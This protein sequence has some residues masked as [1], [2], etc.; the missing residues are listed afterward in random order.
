M[1]NLAFLI[2]IGIAAT[3]PILGTVALIKLVTDIKAIQLA[4]AIVLVAPTLFVSLFSSVW[5]GENLT[6]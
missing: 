3:A 1:K 5:V 4:L 6:K 2:L